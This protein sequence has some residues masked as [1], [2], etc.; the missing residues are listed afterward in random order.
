MSGAPGDARTDA[1]RAGDGFR[2]AVREVREAAFRAV[3]A[4]GA[5]SGEAAAA[6]DLVVLGEVLDGTG[7]FALA[8]ELDRVPRGRRPLACRDSAGS[9][10]VVLHDPAGRGPLLLGPP[11][12]DLAAA[13]SRPVLLPGAWTPS[14]EWIIIGATART[15]T[16]LLATRVRA[17]GSPG[18]C[19][20]ATA[21]GT[22][23]RADRPGALGGRLTGRTADDPEQHR[24]DLPGEGVLLSRWDGAP[25]KPGVPPA[26]T[27]QQQHERFAAAMEH[28]LRVASGPWST[29]YGA[30][31][32]YLV[33]DRQ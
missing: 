11:A 25:P 30:S 18:A 9:T 28:G 23:Y 20:L 19:A 7:V 3:V 22:V 8:D 14:V 29:V 31:R 16:P 24:A 32:D 13:A 15:G 27:P 33:P 12:A 4:A 6:A 5:S 26:R 17:D 10:V 21:D 2:V 1:H